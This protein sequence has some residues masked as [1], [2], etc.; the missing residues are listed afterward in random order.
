MKFIFVIY[1]C[2][3]MNH[4][5]Y[6]GFED[7]KIM[8]R[9]IMNSTIPRNQALPLSRALTRLI[10][11]TLSMGFHPCL[12]SA[13]YI[14]KLIFIMTNLRYLTRRY[15]RLSNFDLREYQFIISNHFILA[16]FSDSNTNWIMYTM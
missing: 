1:F 7:P 3:V 6:L 9:F 10:F 5:D 16:E 11:E 14:T 4:N 12:T 13:I 15:R 8:A 2:Q